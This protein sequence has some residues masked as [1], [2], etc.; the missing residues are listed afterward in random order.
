MKSLILSSLLFASIAW[1][2]P[3]ELFKQQFATRTLGPLAE[4]AFCWENAAGE[5]GDYRGDKPQRLASVTKLFT[6]LLTLESLSADKTWTTTVWINGTRIHIAGSVDPWFEEEKILS[7]IQALKEKGITKISELTFDGAF[8]FTDTAQTRHTPASFALTKDALARYFTPT[9][10]LG[11]YAKERIKA[12]QEFQKE[13]GLALTLPSSG[14]AT[15]KIAP[16]DKNPLMNLPGSTIHTHTSRPLHAILK[17][18]NVM[19]KNMVA[20]LLFEQ[21]KRIKV[22]ATVFTQYGIAATEYVFHSGSGLPVFQGETRLDNT[23]TCRSILTLLRGLEKR[24]QALNLDLES[25]IGVGT[26]LGSYKERFLNDQSLKEAI[27]AKTGTLKN[28]SS[29]AG[30]VSAASPTRFVIL[31]HT[32]NTMAARDWQDA[33]LAKWFNGGAQSRG[34]I[35]ENIYPL[36]GAFFN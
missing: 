20:N 22:P 9:G 2:G 27:M 28:S 32:A 30:W 5:K 33:F 12:A 14:I 16:V 36:E 35:R 18:M 6:T 24:A 8:V 7:L 10:A 3:V 23:A 15:V 4:Q 21:S 26:D 19:S 34:Y 17:A 13:E 1:A 29:L 31:N 25:I 11:A